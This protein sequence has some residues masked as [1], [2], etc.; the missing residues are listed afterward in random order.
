MDTKIQPK[1]MIVLVFSSILAIGSY[2]IPLSP[3]AL[4]RNPELSKK[5]MQSMPMKSEILA[6]KPVMTRRFRS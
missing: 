5:L 3:R 4:V 1:Q 2:W 6:R